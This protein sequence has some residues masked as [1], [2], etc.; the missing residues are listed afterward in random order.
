MYR[1]RYEFKEDSRA[2]S[3]APHLSH[4]HWT[5]QIRQTLSGCRGENHILFS[6]FSTYW[7]AVQNL[8]KYT[9]F[10]TEVGQLTNLQFWSEDSSSKRCTCLL[11]ALAGWSYTR[12]EN[13]LQ[14]QYSGLLSQ[15]WVLRR[16]CIGGYAYQNSG[17][18]LSKLDLLGSCLDFHRGILSIPLIFCQLHGLA[19]LQAIIALINFSRCKIRVSE[20]NSIALWTHSTHACCNHRQCKLASD[21]VIDS[22]EVFLSAGTLLMRIAT[23]MNCAKLRM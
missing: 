23:A 12:I 2:R 8:W 20:L 11:N 22:Q 6:G 5:S 7:G 16:A 3:I 19:Q 14:Q 15:G 21:R 10:L 9:N 13:N 4:P 18:E 17:Q 1:D